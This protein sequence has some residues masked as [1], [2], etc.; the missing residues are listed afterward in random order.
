MPDV[1]ASEATR[2]KSAEEHR[3][4]ITCHRLRDKGTYAHPGT[5]RKLTNCSERARERERAREKD[6]GIK[7]GI[8]EGRRREKE[9]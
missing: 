4:C 5:G 8:G 2:D 7:I 1:S 9:S 3:S 6:G